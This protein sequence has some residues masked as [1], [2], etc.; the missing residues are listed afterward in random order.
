MVCPHMVHVKKF[1]ASN[2]IISHHDISVRWWKSYI[3]FS[4]K[5]ESDCSS[6]EKE[7]KQKLQAIRQ[8][9]CKGPNFIAKDDDHTFSPFHRVYKFGKESNVHFK[10]ATECSIA[11]LFQKLDARDRVI[12]YTRDEVHIALKNAK[13][14]IPV[15]M[16][17]EVHFPDEPITN[18]DDVEN[19][20][21]DDG[22]VVDDGEHSNVFL[23]DQ[24]VDDALIESTTIVTDCID[25]GTRAIFQ[26]C[27]VDVNQDS[28]VYDAIMSRVKELVSLVEASRN[29]KERLTL[30]EGALDQIICNEKANVAS[31]KLAPKGAL[32]SACPVG[33]VRRTYVSSWNF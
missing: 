25:F 26:E 16:S 32:V 14:T 23:D 30:V 7:I 18:I 5:N 8:N 4:M 27:T 24:D 13:K 17:Q 9:D 29:T 3:Y 6:T 19:D 11:S 15:S 20:A 21:T 12:N 22:N 28:K 1:Y 33:K 2:P 10:N 31:E